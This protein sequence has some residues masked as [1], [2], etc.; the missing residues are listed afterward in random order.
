VS[1]ADKGGSTDAFVSWWTDGCI[2]HIAKVSEG[3]PTHVIE[4]A[5]CIKLFRNL[6][7]D[8]GLPL[9]LSNE[10]GQIPPD[11]PAVETYVRQAYAAHTDAQAAGY[12]LPK[13]AAAPGGLAPNPNYINLPG[14]KPPGQRTSN[15][16][17]SGGYGN[18]STGGDNPRETHAKGALDQWGFPTCDLRPAKRFCSDR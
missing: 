1:S 18:S 12:A 7:A 10:E 15:H 3:E 9:S 4:I 16:S 2:K 11:W 8:G 6:L 17:S 14:E 5:P 13:R